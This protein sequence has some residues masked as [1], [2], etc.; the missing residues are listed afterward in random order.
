MAIKSE[1]S[2]EPIARNE[3]MKIQID[4]FLLL[5]PPDAPISIFLPVLSKGASQN[6]FSDS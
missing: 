1:K 5:P 6:R 2:N 4:E 3:L